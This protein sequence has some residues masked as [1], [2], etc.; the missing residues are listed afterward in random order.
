[1]VISGGHTIIQRDEITED[2]L[3]GWKDPTIPISQRRLTESQLKEMYEGKTNMLFKILE[4]CVGESYTSNSTILELGCSTGYYYEILNYLMGVKINYTG[5][6]YSEAMI[7]AAKRYYPDTTF[8]VADGANLPFEDK[9]FSIVISGSILIHNLDYHSHV[10]ETARVASDRVIVHRTQLCKSRP[11]HFLKK[12]AY[13]VD[14]LEVRFNESELLSLFE[15]ERFVCIK[16]YEYLTET[17]KDEFESTH[18][19]ERKD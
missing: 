3:V 10:R 19:L 4:L 9:Q 17:S 2:L 5:V 15:K 7:E 1:M 16:T 8:V 13:D 18:L 11:T 14:V 6:D 12:K